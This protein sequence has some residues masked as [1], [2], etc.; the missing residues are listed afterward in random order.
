MKNEVRAVVLLSPRAARARQVVLHV[1]A[2]NG[3]GELVRNLDRGAITV[4]SEASRQMQLEAGE[5]QSNFSPRTPKHYRKPRST[6][7]LPLPQQ[8]T[9]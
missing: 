1:T 8:M 9:R 5:T 3:Q 7:D 2:T 6:L 4:S